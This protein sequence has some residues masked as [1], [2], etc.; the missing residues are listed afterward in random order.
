VFFFL[1]K[2]EQS[3]IVARWHTYT[4]NKLR[5]VFSRILAETG[6]ISDTK[7]KELRRVVVQKELADHLIAIGAQR[8]L[9]AI[10]GGMF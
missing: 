7:K 1:D 9:E 3:E 8:Y 6:L 10:Q 4:L 2:G 5:Q